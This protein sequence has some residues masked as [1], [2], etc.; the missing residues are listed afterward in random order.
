MYK[1]SGV[2][3]ATLTESSQSMKYVKI[4]IY[5]HHGDYRELFSH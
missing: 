4:Y 2:K 1:L 3:I 5:G